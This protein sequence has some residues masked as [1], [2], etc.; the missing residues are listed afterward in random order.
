MMKR[1]MLA[2]GLVVGLARLS[3]AEIVFDIEDVV[4]A[5]GQQA[6]VGV[7]ASGTAGETF[8]DFNLPIEIGGDGRG[9]S[10]GI[11]GFSGGDFVQEVDSF[12]SD[13]LVNTSALPPFFTQDYEGIFSDGGF[14]IALTPTPTRL[15][16]ILIDTDDFLLQGTVPISFTSTTSTVNPL[17]VVSSAGT[18]NGPSAGVMSFNGG[19]I[20][21]T[22][23]PEPA[24]GVL[25]LGVLGICA[26]RWNRKR[27]VVAA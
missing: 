4:V 5:P 8:S 12:T 18:F 11:V 15:F 17:T 27:K 25:V 26:V 7:F 1:L 6:V 20:S 9:F 23:V 16:N 19:S 2:A 14:A 10:S 13:V 21:V 22:A 24:S 3:S